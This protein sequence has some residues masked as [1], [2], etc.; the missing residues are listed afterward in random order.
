MRTGAHGMM[1]VAFFA[2]AACIAVLG[3]RAEALAQ[4]KGEGVKLS[5]AASGASLDP[6]SSAK[7]TVKIENR[8]RGEVLLKQ[9]RH[10]FFSLDVYGKGLGACARG[11]CFVAYFRIAE[12]RAIKRGETYT[13][14][15]ELADLYWRD[16]A[17]EIDTKFPKNM[18]EVI[19]P[20]DYYLHAALSVQRAGTRRSAPVFIEARSPRRIVKV[21]QP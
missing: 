16:A 18:A 10:V 8:A 11:D 9:N 19:K 4:A 2:A 21:G 3:C 15:V 13:L 20:G 7:A 6:R 5:V 1:R 12:D 14:E 17:A